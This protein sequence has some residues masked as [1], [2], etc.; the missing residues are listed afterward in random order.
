ML[1]VFLEVRLHP[2]VG[3]A[4]VAGEPSQPTEE[5]LAEDDGDRHDA[6]YGP[7]E[8]AA[9]RQQEEEGGDEFQAGCQQG[10]KHVADAVGYHAHVLF[11]AVGDVAAVPFASSSLVDA[12]EAREEP[13][14][15]AV[16]DPDVG[17]RGEAGAQ[18]GGS[19]LRGHG[20]Q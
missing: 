13:Q 5:D 16:L 10:G 12:D 8:A 6:H 7:C 17:L 3:V 20:A 15:Q 19:G 4:Y 18:Q 1:E 9:Q 14:T 11:E 2:A